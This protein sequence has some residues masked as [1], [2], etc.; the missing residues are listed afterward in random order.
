MM[1]VNGGLN[2]EGSSNVRDGLQSL[3]S[4]IEE[5]L[6]QPFRL[7]VLSKTARRRQS[8]VVIAF[9]KAAEKGTEVGLAQDATTRRRGSK[10]RQDASDATGLDGQSKGK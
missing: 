6:R 4:G 2:R 5:A 3:S 10:S 7:E 8:K 1:S 9:G